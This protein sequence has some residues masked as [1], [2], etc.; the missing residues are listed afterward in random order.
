MQ[1][2]LPMIYKFKSNAT[3]DVIMTQPVGDD[4]LK[5]IGKSPATKGIIESGSMPGAI[6]A[7]EAAIEAEDQ[8]LAQAE[9]EASGEGKKAVS[10]GGVSLRQRCW[11]LIEMMKRSAAENADIVWGV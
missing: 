8:A 6:A 3:G 5:L 11:P 10:P 4:L 9:K 7:L 1:V 2:T